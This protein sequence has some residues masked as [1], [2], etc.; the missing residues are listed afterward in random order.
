VLDG[1]DD[2]WTVKSSQVIAEGDGPVTEVR[3]THDEEHL[4][5]RV[6][7]AEERAWQRAPIRIGFATHVEGNGGLPGAAGGAPAADHG[8]VVGPGERAELLQAAWLDPLPWLYGITHDYVEFDTRAMRPASGAWSKPRQIVNRPL[9]VP[10]VGRQPA[11]FVDQSVLKWGSGDPDADGFDRRNLVMG[12]G[13]VLELRVPWALIGYADPSSHRSL[14]GK[15]DG[16]MAAVRTG[17][18]GITVQVGGEAPLET[19]GYDWEDWNRAAWRERRKAGWA[20]LRDA[21]ARTAADGA[22]KRR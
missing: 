9:A 4:W 16:T 22:G 2:D 7:L 12:G 19:A 10:G 21:F 3:A 20:T 11:E 18:V 5:L 15:P 8:I 13:H 6:K 1:R 17:R 14:R